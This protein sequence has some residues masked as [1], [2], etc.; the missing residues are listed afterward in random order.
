VSHSPCT[1]VV[2]Q[3]DKKCPALCGTQRA[4]HSLPRVPES[5][6]WEVKRLGRKAYNSHTV[7]KNTWSFS[8]TSSYSFISCCVVKQLYFYIYIFISSPK[9]R[10]IKERPSPAIKTFKTTSFLFYLFL[11]Q[12]WQW[13]CMRVQISVLLSK[14]PASKRTHARARV[15][16]VCLY[17][18]RYKQRIFPYAEL[19]F[20]TDGICLLRGTNQIFKYTWGQSSSF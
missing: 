20:M 18:L 14:F 2:D 9:L 6:S 17:G 5:L 16:Y 19:V 12:G 8:F 10:N 1:L 3:L 15:A 13:M 11:L 4:H 7:P